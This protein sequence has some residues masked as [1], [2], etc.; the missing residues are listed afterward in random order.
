MRHLL[1]L[2][3]PIVF[4]C[5]GSSTV[6]SNCSEPKSQPLSAACCPAYGIDACGANL[7]CAAF[8]G[9]TQATCYANGSR[10]PG[11]SC[12]D[13]RQ[14]SSLSCN[15]DAKACRYLPAQACRTEIGCAQDPSGGR[16]V[17]APAA[18]GN[19]P[20]N[21]CVPLGTS[22]YC[23]IDNDCSSTYCI[24][25][26]CTTG[27]AASPCRTAKDCDAPLKCTAGVCSSCGG[28]ADCT[29]GRCTAGSCVG[30]T[31]GGA[32]T[33]TKDC[34]AGLECAPSRQVCA[35]P[36]GTNVGC[37]CGAP[38]AEPKCASGSCQNGL[39]L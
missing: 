26:H 30:V 37:F 38:C 23:D 31:N 25:R 17:C 33:Q 18:V 1:F 24:E 29:R 3:V 15:G 14:C 2:L 16:Y 19:L 4:A 32:C 28:D 5:T 8:D 22:N 7:F 10:L 36:S 11:D 20:A 6:A 21:T 39:C 27:A 12:T 34:A 13:G 9:R 35:F